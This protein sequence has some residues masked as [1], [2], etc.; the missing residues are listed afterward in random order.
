MLCRE[1][2]PECLYVVPVSDHWNMH[3]ISLCLLR[4]STP[5]S[6]DMLKVFQGDVNRVTR[7][8]VIQIPAD[9]PWL[10]NL[11]NVST[12][13]GCPSKTLESF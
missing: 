8:V 4:S 5:S 7:E 10:D 9:Q 2:E 12:N 11:N 13:C 1:G 6:L 3:F